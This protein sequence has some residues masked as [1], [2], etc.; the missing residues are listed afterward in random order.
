MQK[1]SGPDGWAEC[2]HKIGSAAATSGEVIRIY[3]A[4]PDIPPAG[5]PDYEG[6]AIQESIGPYQAL[7][8]T[9][10]DTKNPAGYNNANAVAT[11]VWGGS[12]VTGT[13]VCDNKD[14]F[15]DSLNVTMRKLTDVFKTTALGG[16]GVGF[17]Q[18][19]QFKCG[20]TVIGTYLFQYRARVELIDD[21]VHVIGEI[22]VDLQG[23]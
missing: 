2:S 16:D 4:T 23:D 1:T 3:R 15:P 18:T 7:G 17:K 12:S 6:I 14:E 5:Q 22:K 8:F 19:Q 21:K 20:G 11:A 13:F 10:A 9:L